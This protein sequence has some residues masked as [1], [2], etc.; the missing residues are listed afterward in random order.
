MPPEPAG[1]DPSAVLELAE[2]MLLPFQ[3]LLGTNLLGRTRVLGLSAPK[4]GVSGVGCRTEGRKPVVLRPPGPPWSSALQTTTYL[5]T[6]SCLTNWPC[7][8]TGG[9]FSSRMFWGMRSA[10]GLSTGRAA[11]SPRCAAPPLSMP[12]RRSR[13]RS[14]GVLGPGQ[15]GLWRWAGS[16]PWTEATHPVRP[17]NSISGSQELEFQVLGS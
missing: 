8:S 4:A 17:G 10:A 5:R 3:G 7:A 6:S 15:G 16:A 2:Q 14:D 9:C 12:R 1:V 13:P 11:K